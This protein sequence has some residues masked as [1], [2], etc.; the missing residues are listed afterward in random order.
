[1]DRRTRLRP[2]CWRRGGWIAAISAVLAATACTTGSGGGFT[3]DGPPDK[4]DTIQL[5]SVSTSEGRLEGGMV[6]KLAGKHFVDGSGSVAVAFGDKSAMVGAVDDTSVEVTVPA[7]TVE[8]SVDVS[9]TNSTGTAKLPGAFTYRC[10]THYV[11]LGSQCVDFATDNNHC[12]T[13][14]NVCSATT[15]CLGG[16]CTVPKPMPT[17]R[18]ARGAVLGPDGKIYVIGGVDGS[19]TSGNRVETYDPRTNTWATKNDFSGGFFEG[20][21]VTAGGKI[22]A[23][24]CG[25]IYSY[26]AALDSWSER[27]KAPAVATSLQHCGTVVAPD[28]RIL[29]LGGSAGDFSN[30]STSARAYTPAS[31]TWMTLQPM[32]HARNDFGTAT[33]V[34]GRIFAIGGG[35]PGEGLLVDAL[36]PASGAWTSTAPTLAQTSGASA[37]VSA[38]GKT[39]Y[40]AA[41]TSRF[42]IYDV[43]ANTWTDGPPLTPAHAGSLSFRAGVV[44]GVDGRVYVVGGGRKPAV[45][46]GLTRVVEVYDP[47]RGTWISGPP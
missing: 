9:V 14:G 28:G 38:D 22:Y 24:T 43:A 47:K 25:R 40:V 30:R 6:V 23:V 18:Q 41:G 27:A 16:T 3:P 37:A 33:S 31:D 8:G 45:A 34:D 19:I 17:A 15:T 2:A 46:P 12:G 4:S 26:D 21:A 39:I 5:T 36:D 20:R 42:Q 32:P 44:V 11:G 7:G 10:P 29:V 1:M 13:Q 35:G